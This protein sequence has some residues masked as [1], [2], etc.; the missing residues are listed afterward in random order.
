MDIYPSL[1]DWVEIFYNSIPSFVRTA[2][3]DESV[4]DSKSKAAVF[5][6]RYKEML[7]N[8]MFGLIND[9]F[10][11]WKDKFTCVELCSLR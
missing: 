8:M 3:A 2:E 6:T 9:G 7:D 5:A 10:G 1:E 4:D 11:A